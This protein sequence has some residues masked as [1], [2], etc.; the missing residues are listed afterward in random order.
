MKRTI[1][2]CS[3]AFIL[4][5]VLNVGTCEGASAL[6]VSDLKCEYK[7]NPLGIDVV[8]PRLSW[9][10]SAPQ[11]ETV[12]TAYRIRAAENVED[13]GR[14]RRHVW[15]SGRVKSDQSVHIVYDG[16]RDD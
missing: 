11:R 3:T 9:K 10:L 14:V 1:I 16:R 8:K 13:L 15:N 6:S 12:Q 7:T 5:L 4:A 2:I